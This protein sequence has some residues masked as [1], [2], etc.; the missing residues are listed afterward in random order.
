[1][2]VVVTGGGGFLGSAICRQ[3]LARG[4]K[5]IACQRG[6]AL[7]AQALGAEVKRG[8][9]TDAEHLD[10]VIAGA[11]GVIH[12]AGKAGAWGRRLDYFDINYGGTR[13]VIA[14]CLK[15]DVRKLVFT[16]SPSVVHADT[17]I[18]GGN[19]SL[20]YPDHFDAHYPA[21]KAL[22]EQAVMAANGP[23][24]ATVSLR[25]HLI[26]GPGDNQLLPRLLERARRGTLRIPGADKL[27]DTVYVEN[28]A[29]AHVL[30]LDKLASAPQTVGGKT[31][32]VT[33]DEPRSQAEIMT[34]LLAAA[35]ID[36]SI[37]PVPAPLA[38]AAGF[39]VETTWRLL[40][41]KS[42][43][44]VTRWSAR[45]LSTAHWYDITAAKQDLG[46]R[47]QIS[48]EEGMARLKTALQSKGAVNTG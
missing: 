11:D 27:I 46:Y 43:P 25:P 44:I 10:R 6:A 17:D 7:Q 37:R 9:V 30:A 42:E 8:S 33:N 41:L 48:I 22:A 2:R 45:L 39:V 20:P 13:N 28:A 4:D 24:L 5:V 3:L 36:V 38:L 31:Y 34:G 1:M 29:L 40:G 47:A 32:F 12:T 14:A 26:W 15:H 21:S 18:E 19:E 35:G 23:R 16:S